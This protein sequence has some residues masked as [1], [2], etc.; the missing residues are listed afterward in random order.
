MSKVRKKED[1]I[2][3]GEVT[4]VLSQDFVVA[5]HTE[6]YDQERVKL[7]F[8]SRKL[9]SQE[10]PLKLFLY[11]RQVAGPKNSSVSDLFQTIL[12]W[13]WDSLD[14]SSEA[15]IQTVDL[16]ASAVRGKL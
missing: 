9:P 3:V 4:T 1:G 7:E 6:G 10:E 12:G 14:T 2:L 16:P 13:Q 8:T 11:L 5:T 15:E